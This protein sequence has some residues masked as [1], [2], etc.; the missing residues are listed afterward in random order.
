MKRLL[1]SACL[2]CTT[3]SACSGLRY[4]RGVGFS[5]IDGEPTALPQDGGAGGTVSRAQGPI[6]ALA[7][8]P[9][10][11]LQ[12]A[13][14]DPA[15][16]AGVAI[17][18]GG[19]SPADA[20]PVSLGGAPAMLSLVEVNGLSHAVLRLPEGMRGQLGTAAGPAFAAAVPRLT[21]CLAAGGAIRRDRPAQSAGLAVPL[22]CR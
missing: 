14:G 22:N 5:G 11:R 13:A 3:L 10:L 9:P 17:A 6:E 18:N 12:V 21:G 1:L 4:Q 16:L 20:V 15:Q 2:L 19:R 8:R 7:M